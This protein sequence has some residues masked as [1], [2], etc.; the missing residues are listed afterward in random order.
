MMPDA[1]P[2]EIYRT[3]Q[4]DIEIEWTLTGT[5]PDNKKLEI[6]RYENECN[7]TT[8]R[9]GPQIRFYCRCRYKHRC[10]FMLVAIKTTEQRYHVYK[11]GEH[12]EHSARKPKS[13]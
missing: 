13:E 11:H 4:D 10:K 8:E 5:F 1:N 9:E 6:F 3:Q 7:P 2:P 12:S